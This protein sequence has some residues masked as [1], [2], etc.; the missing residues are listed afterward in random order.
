MK[1]KRVKV[2][3]GKKGGKEARKEKDGAVPL[4]KKMLHLVLRQGQGIF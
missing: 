4:A 2:V 1:D 3:P